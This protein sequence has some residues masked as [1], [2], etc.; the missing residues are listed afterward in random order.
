MMKKNDIFIYISNALILA[1]AIASYIY[2]FPVDRAHWENWVIIFF[3]LPFVKYFSPKDYRHLV[4]PS[5]I[6]FALLYVLTSQAVFID[7][8][9][10]FGSSLFKTHISLTQLPP[11]LFTLSTGIVFPLLFEGILSKKTSR[12]ISYMV[13]STTSTIY[14]IATLDFALTVFKGSGFLEAYQITGILIYMNVYLLLYKGYE[15]ITLLIQPNPFVTEL[16]LTTFI[17]SIIGF[18]FSLYV[19]EEDRGKM[20][21]QNIGYPILVG[22]MASFILTFLLVYFP[23]SIYSIFITTLI[24]IVSMSAVKHSDRKENYHLNVIGDNGAK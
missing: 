1:P 12:A 18:V 4:Y 21:I 22:A 24:V 17:I 11:L 6:I 20:S 3:I 7:H 19:S 2:V 23:Y 5:V 8:L 9:Q 14:T 15:F 10:F 13:I 16:L